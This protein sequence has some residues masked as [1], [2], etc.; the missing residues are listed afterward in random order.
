M[1]L[2]PG[3]LNGASWNLPCFFCFNC[4]AC[5]NTLAMAAVA[6]APVAGHAGTMQLSDKISL[7]SGQESA[8]KQSFD[9][10]KRSLAGWE[11]LEIGDVEVRVA[12][13]QQCAAKD[14]PAC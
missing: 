3:C 14:R 10:C 6:V 7:S 1:P 8:E 5:R 12:V 2:S 11:G 13:P 9:V 4:A